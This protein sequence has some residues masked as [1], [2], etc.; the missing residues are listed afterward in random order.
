MVRT[1]TEPLQVN[2]CDVKELDFKYS[3]QVLIKG[4][5][6]RLRIYFDHPDIAYIKFAIEDTRLSK[7][8]VSSVVEGFTDDEIL[9]RVRKP[10][11]EILQDISEYKVIFLT[12]PLRIDLREIEELE[13]KNSGTV[14]IIGQNTRLFLGFRGGDFIFVKL[15]TMNTDLN[16]IRV[17]D[18]LDNGIYATVVSSF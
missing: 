13:F 6:T 14:M 16:R 15:S 3:G 11:G 2:L 17:S 4:E 7:M 8:S 10:V 9:I 1:G 12:K 5:N 18:I